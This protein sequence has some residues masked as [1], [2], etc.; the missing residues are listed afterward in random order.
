MKREAA[1]IAAGRFG[2][3]FLD[4][5]VFTFGALVLSIGILT[6]LANGQSHVDRPEPPAIQTEQGNALL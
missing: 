2:S 1:C 5:T 3:D 4:W 6:A